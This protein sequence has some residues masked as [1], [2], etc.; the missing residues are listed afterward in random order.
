MIL[1]AIL[2]GERDSKKLA[3][4][5]DHRVKKSQAQV[6]AALTG[7]YRPELLFVISQ[8]EVL[9][10]WRLELISL[11][12]APRILSLRSFQVAAMRTG[13]HSPGRG[14]VFALLA[15]V[16]RRSIPSLSNMWRTFPRLIA[17]SRC[18]MMSKT[19]GEHTTFLKLQLRA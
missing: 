17:Q 11:A 1:D 7:D 3:S 10:V 13:G 19:Q 2:A 6:E 16:S 5:V 14:L 12:D 15:L 9:Q 8:T 18:S 4:L